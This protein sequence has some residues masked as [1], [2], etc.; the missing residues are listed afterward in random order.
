MLIELKI[1]L[2]RWAIVSLAGEDLGE[3]EKRK[4]HGGTRE[5]NHLQETSL[6]SGIN[7]GQLVDGLG[8]WK[9]LKPRYSLEEISGNNQIPFSVL[10]PK[11]VQDKKRCSYS[12]LWVHIKKPHRVER[13][14]LKPQKRNVQQYCS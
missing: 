13:Q 12:N 5:K 3:V 7:T 2:T 14:A 11:C 8:R 9:N 10:K 4:Y 1:K 6:S